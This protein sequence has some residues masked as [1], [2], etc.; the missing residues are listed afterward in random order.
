MEMTWEN[1]TKLFTWDDSILGAGSGREHD[2][3]LSQEQRL[4]FE[5]AGGEPLAAPAPDVRHGERTRNLCQATALS[6]L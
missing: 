3:K 2:H 5:P 6:F 4:E 1:L